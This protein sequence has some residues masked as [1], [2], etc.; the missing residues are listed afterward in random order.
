MFILGL[1]L[2]ESSKRPR[3]HVCGPKDLPRETRI[4]TVTQRRLLAHRPPPA[5]RPPWSASVDSI[6][7]RNGPGEPTDDSS[8][9]AQTGDAAASPLRFRLAS[10][11]QICSRNRRGESRFTNKFHFRILYAF[12][13]TFRNDNDA[14]LFSMKILNSSLKTR[15][16]I[17]KRLER[18]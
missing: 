12:Q 13:L 1:V 5:P 17:I 16:V 2:G 3:Q 6:S 4:F 7:D 9:R 8:E 18:S 15:K 14:E 11:I 10:D